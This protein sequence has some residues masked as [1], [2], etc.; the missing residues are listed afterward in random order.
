MELGIRAWLEE[1]APLNV[2][3]DGQKCL[4]RGKSVPDCCRKT[5]ILDLLRHAG[6][7]HMSSEDRT[8]C[9]KALDMIEAGSVPDMTP[10]RF[11]PPPED[12]DG[13]IH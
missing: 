1:L 8:I 10:A 7:D 5:I 4:T 6:E 12:T 3:P 11:L 13:D 2:C 9:Q